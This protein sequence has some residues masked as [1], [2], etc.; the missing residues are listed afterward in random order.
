MRAV[1]LVSPQHAVTLQTH[2]W[3]GPALCGPARGPLCLPAAMCA[4]PPNPEL[5][6]HRSGVVASQGLECQ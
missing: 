2:A 5:G 6:V 1:A 3:G 4:V